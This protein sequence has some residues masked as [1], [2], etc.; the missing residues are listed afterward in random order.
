MV[1][2]GVRV[3]QTPKG[4]CLRGVPYAY[5]KAYIPSSYMDPLGKKWFTAYIL[6]CYNVARRFQK[7]PPDSDIRIYMCLEIF[8]AAGLLGF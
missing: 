5:F 4:P 1:G 2:L 8:L 3:F 7:E 6:Q